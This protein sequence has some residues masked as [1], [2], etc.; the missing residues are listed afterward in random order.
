M[1]T[2]APTARY[3]ADGDLYLDIPPDTSHQ[4]IVAVYCAVA[5]QHIPPG[6]FDVEVFGGPSTVWVNWRYAQRAEAI[7]RLFWPTLQVNAAANPH[8][9][10]RDHTRAVRQALADARKAIVAAETL[11]RCGAAPA[12]SF[13]PRAGEIAGRR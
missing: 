9:Q 4:P 11:V 8:Y 13:G 7:A 1:A 5:R 3:E 12:P 6:F 10:A 2:P